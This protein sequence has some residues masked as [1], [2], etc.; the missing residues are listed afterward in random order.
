MVLP[1]AGVPEVTCGLWWL[2]GGG[3]ESRPIAG[4]GVLWPTASSGGGVATGAQRRGG[5]SGIVEVGPG[6]EGLAR[7]PRSRGDGGV[8]GQGDMEVTAGG[9]S[10]SGGRGAASLML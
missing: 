5:Q 10:S 9:S 6:T 1:Q 2:Y 8:R 4:V 7:G 3:V